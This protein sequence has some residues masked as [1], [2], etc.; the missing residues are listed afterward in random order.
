MQKKIRS[1]GLRI[2]FYGLLFLTQ[3]VRGQNHVH[4]INIDGFV[5]LFPDAGLRFAGNPNFKFGI[6]VK[7]ARSFYAESGNAFISDGFV[8]DLAGGQALFFNQDQ[9]LGGKDEHVA[10]EFKTQFYLFAFN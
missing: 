5:E 4:V 1:Q 7:S 6:Q 2:V 9:P 3:H 10:N 8:F